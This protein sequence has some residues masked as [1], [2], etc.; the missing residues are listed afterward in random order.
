M[1]HNK[2]THYSFYSKM[3]L[4]CKAKLITYF[5]V[6][7]IGIGMPLA[8][9][10]SYAMMFNNI[11]YFLFPVPLM[12]IFFFVWLLSPTG[13]ALTQSDLLI[14]R[15]IGPLIIP[16]DSIKSADSIENL[17]KQTG[18]V[19]RT[20]GA[21]G[22]WGWFGFFWSKSWGH[23]KAYATRDSNIVLINLVDNK[24]VLVTPD[25]KDGFLSTINK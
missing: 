11:L 1:N 8:L 5:V 14:I 17:H 15:R 19:L 22:A 9:G 6:I 2:Q 25:D 12:V 3:S 10:I 13:I 23:F 24:K 16:R 7:G 20:W 18:F 4:D 21:G